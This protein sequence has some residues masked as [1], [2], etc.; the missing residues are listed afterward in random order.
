[1]SPRENLTAAIAEQ[2]RIR[3]LIDAT[4][5]R[6]ADLT[7]KAET[8]ERQA[9]EAAQAGLDAAARRL[10]AGDEPSTDSA[11][12]TVSH[13][14]NEA[15]AA[16]HAV[17]LA[18][19]ERVTLER[20]LKAGEVAVTGAWLGNFRHNR[21]AGHRDVQAAVDRLG[22]ALARLLAA[23]LIL[24]A[25]VGERFAFDPNEHPPADL[26]R[27]RPLIAA[28]VGAIPARF[29]PADFGETIARSAEAIAR[30]EVQHDE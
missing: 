24:D 4:E 9:E 30:E 14:R 26:W 28:L 25:A 5:A 8:L 16:R 20:E 10:V 27:P 13:L 12:E 22:E 2:D 19:E 7:A 23:D 6:I 29:R 21:D 18:E 17:V 15:A 3:A 1:M 11:M